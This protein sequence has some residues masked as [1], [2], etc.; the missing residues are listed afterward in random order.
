MN[1]I[2]ISSSLSLS[3]S[4]ITLIITLFIFIPKELLTLANILALVLFNL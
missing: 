3:I 1:N 4:V 2:V